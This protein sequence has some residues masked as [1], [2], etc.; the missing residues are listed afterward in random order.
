M[1]QQAIYAIIIFLITYALIISEKIHRTIVAML[2]ATLMIVFGIVN[3]ETALHHIDFNT[4]GLLTGMM[5]IVTVTAQ[6]G[7]F[8]YIA[9]WAAKKAKGD[10]IRILVALGLITAFASAFLDNVTTVLLMVP[11]T[12]SITRQLRV[13]PMPYLLTQIFTSNIGGTAT[14][15]GDPPNIMIGSAVK[16]LTFAAFIFNLAPIIIVILTVTVGILAFWYRKQLKTT[17]DLQQE[18]MQM[19]AEDE[20]SDPTLLKKCL[21]ILALTIAGF[22]AHQA[23]HIESAT[24]ALTGAFLLLLLTGEHYLEDALT[25]VEWTTIFFFVGLFVLVSGLVETGVIAKL[26]QEAIALTGG[27]LTATAMLILWM[28]AIASAFVDNIPFVATMIPM[29]QEM[30]KIGLTDLEPLWWSLALGACLG[31]NGTLI[32]ASANV[33]VAGMAAKEGHHISFLKFMAIGFPLMILSIAI[34]TIY[35]YL[36]YLM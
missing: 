19:S 30:G 32:G 10:P 11:V 14:L 9:I 21:L 8:K 35:V 31:G 28:S 25:R 3:Q 4:L 12:F 6:T 27:D 22:F 5:I 2:G 17:P 24:V 29:I 15:I 13:S 34:S 16:E 36:R 20:L 26:A 23:L 33:I 1:E 7:L 18:L